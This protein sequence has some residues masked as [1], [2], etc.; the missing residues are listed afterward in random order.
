MI[1]CLFHLFQS[2]ASSF[3]SQ[4]L[5]LFLKSSRSC[6]LLPTHFTSAI[7]VQLYNEK[8]NFF[9]EYVQSNW[10]LYSGYC[11]EASS[12]LLVSNNFYISYFLWSFYLLHS[13]PAPQFIA[14]QILPPQ[15]SK[16]PGLWAIWSNAPNITHFFF[17]FPLYNLPHC[18]EFKGSYGPHIVIHIKF[19][20]NLCLAASKGDT[21]VN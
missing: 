2:S 7:C 12:S 3:S 17:S 13:P 6:V 5:L 1:N 10:L 14:L 21:P 4:Y 18:Q 15:L 8:D 19:K 20:L 11:S 16:C 9:L